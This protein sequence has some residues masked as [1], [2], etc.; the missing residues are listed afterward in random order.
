[1]VMYHLDLCCI[2]RARLFKQQS[3]PVCHLRS[4]A[5]IHSTRPVPWFEYLKSAFLILAVVPY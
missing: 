5:A 4:Y 2:N 1:M 3:H